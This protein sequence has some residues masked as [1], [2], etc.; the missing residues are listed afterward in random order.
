MRKRKKL[1]QERTDAKHR[2]QQEWDK[3]QSDFSDINSET[4]EERRDEYAKALA[5]VRKRNKSY[6][7]R[8]SINGP[9]SS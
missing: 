3:L 9:Y 7:D 2:Y 8:R 4:K 1:S 5:D 6:L